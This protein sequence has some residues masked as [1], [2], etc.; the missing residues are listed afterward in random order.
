MKRFVAR[1]ARVGRSFFPPRVEILESRC[2]LST[3]QWINRGGLDS[4]TDGFNAAYGANAAAARAIVEEAI[5][6]WAAII[7]DF[8]YASGSN[9]YVLSVSAADEPGFRAVTRDITADDDGRP[10]SA[11]ITLDDNADGAGWFFD[12]TPADNAEFSSLLNRFTT[13][14]GTGGNR[15]LYSTIAHEIGHAMGIAGGG[16]LLLN[17]FLTDAGVDQVDGDDDP[18]YLF[19]GDTATATLVSRSGLHVYEGPADPDYPDAPIRANDLMNPG[20][21]NPADGRRLISDLDA[22]ILADAYG[23]TINL[24]STL[25]TFLVNYNTTTNELVLNGDPQIVDDEFSVTIDGPNLAVMVNDAQADFLTLSVGSVQVLAADGDDTLNVDSRDAPGEVQISLDGGDGDDTA[26]IEATSLSTPVVVALGADSNRTN[27]T[28]ASRNLDDLDGDVRINNGGFAADV[29]TFHDQDNPFGDRFTITHLSVERQ[30]S[31]TVTTRFAVAAMIIHAGGGSS[32]FNVESLV[33]T[34]TLVINAGAGDDTVNL[35]PAFGIFDL[36]G[37]NLDPINGDVTI[38]GEDGD[39]ALVLTDINSAADQEI[40]IGETTV[41]RDG[42]G[43]V[44]YDD[45]LE[46]ITVTAGRGNDLL[47]ARGANLRTALFGGLGDDDIFGSRFDDLIHGGWGF[48][49]MHGGP[50]ADQWVQEG[51]PAAD[52][53]D[54]LPLSTSQMQATR[55]SLSSTGPLEIDRFTFDVLDRAMV[56]TGA[57]ADRLS[58]TIAAPW[59]GLEVDLGPGN[60]RADIAYTATVAVPP[61]PPSD[62][63]LSEIPV[64]PPS[65]TITQVELKLAA[66]NGDDIV[67]LAADSF[68]DVFTEINLDKGNDQANVTFIGGGT[69][70]PSS[71]HFQLAAGGGDDE[72]NLLADSFFDVFTDIDSGSGDDQIT[73]AGRLE[74]HPPDAES[75]LWDVNI[76]TGSGIDGVVCDLRVTTFDELLASIFVTG[77][78]LL[79]LSALFPTGILDMAQAIRDDRTGSQ[80]ALTLDGPDIAI[81]VATGA[82]DDLI[83]LRIDPSQDGSVRFLADTGAGNDSVNS[84]VAGF[85]DVFT[86][87]DLGKGNDKAGLNY[88]AGTPDPGALKLILAAGAGDDEVN[89][90]ADSF[91]DVFTEIDLDTGNDRLKAKIDPAADGSVRFSAYAGVGNDQAFVEFPSDP[92]VLQFL[93]DAGAGNDLVDLRIGTVLPSPP[94]DLSIAYETPTP[95]PVAS[96]FFDFFV[97][98]GAGNDRADVRYVGGGTPYP[99]GNV[100]E[101][102]M[103]ILGDAGNDS[104]AAEIDVRAIDHVLLD[105]EGG[106]GNDLIRVRHVENLPATGL[107]PRPLHLHVLGGDGNDNLS[108]LVATSRPQTLLDMLLDGGKGRDRC[109]VT[110]NVQVINCETTFPV[111]RTTR[112]RTS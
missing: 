34:T 54:F 74:D 33:S 72:L 31:S 58:M 44:T 29:V 108:L 5:N 8:N 28:P 10:I 94:S 99:Q 91:F 20:R 106:K 93:L 42:M 64:P 53:L 110:P 1:R 102:R 67:N 90:M 80:V 17:D 86:E 66:G 52:Q 87:I 41:T 12:A 51:T 77:T 11:S 101:L 9:T 30:H 73:F 62:L 49:N 100:R 13:N 97:D 70:D 68:F 14:A 35:A 71:L 3:I 75:P 60:D 16:S 76:N 69:P 92:G 18:L 84:N 109:K 50:G 79:G 78:G 89:L 25:E 81:D 40:V 43:T 23:Y 61:P 112:K 47:D 82:S 63:S 57:G 65:P 38:H 15:D 37:G 85:F 59:Q 26:N 36:L 6:D 88:V 83:D 45:T 95:L 104:V 46:E 7:Q 2:L 48:D 21:A 4:D 39:D 22:Q 55:S 56:A 103:K 24:P 19:T 105:F 27:L 107:P 111:G 32:D 98:L 96:S